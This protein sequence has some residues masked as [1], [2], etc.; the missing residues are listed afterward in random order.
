VLAGELGRASQGMMKGI[1]EQHLGSTAS[2]VALTL[3][4]KQAQAVIHSAA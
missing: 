4:S 1:A 2:R 3:A